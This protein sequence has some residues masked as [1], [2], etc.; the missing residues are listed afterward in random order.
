MG[1]HFTG[2]KRCAGTGL[3]HTKRH[4]DTLNRDKTV[5]SFLGD[6]FSLGQHLGGC[7]IQIDLRSVAGHLG[8]FGQGKINGIQ[9][10]RWIATCIADQIGRQPLVV[11]HQRFQNVVWGQPL[12]AVTGRNRLGGLNET[13]RPLGEL[14]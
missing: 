5:T 12:V 6:A 3:D 2:L 4:Q 9:H 8:L 1:G 11:I 7:V 10:S 14:G 13:A